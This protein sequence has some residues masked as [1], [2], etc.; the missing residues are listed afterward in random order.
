MK[1]IITLFILMVVFAL[2]QMVFLT[3][4]YYLGEK[5][6]FNFETIVYPLLGLCIFLT[7]L[8]YVFEP[9]LFFFVKYLK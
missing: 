2:L 5:D 7:A 3:S 9:L 4:L 6:V 1:K 8:I